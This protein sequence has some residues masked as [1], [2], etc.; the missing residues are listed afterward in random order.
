MKKFLANPKFPPLSIG[1]YVD[2]THYAMAEKEE[3]VV[4]KRIIDYYESRGITCREFART[5]GVNETTFYRLDQEMQVKNII[6][7]L[8]AYPDIDARELLLGEPC[9]TESE[10][11]KKLPLLP[12][13]A[14]AG[15]LSENI[16]DD[17]QTESIS[18]PSRVTRGADFAIR[19][20]GDS[21]Q[22]RFHSGEV[23]MVKK[24]DPSFFQWG[25]IYVL[26]TNQGCVVK[27]LYPA[28]EDS[29]TC[30]SDNNEFYPDYKVKKSDIYGVGLVVGH[31]G[32]D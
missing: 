11:G 8:K 21:M 32:L 23:L 18:L 2:K 27:R 29:I 22:P 4:K 19:V 20:E 5:S 13:D 31:V 26:A 30:H 6:K 25:K 7:I 15:R 12:F 1:K 14:V 3:A 9:V 10:D 24:I 16:T 17:I 28:D